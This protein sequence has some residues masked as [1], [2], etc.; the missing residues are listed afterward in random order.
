MEKIKKELR[1]Q[2]FDETSWWN[3]L[4]F[5]LKQTTAEGKPPPKKKPSHPFP[6]DPRTPSLR[7]GKTLNLCVGADFLYEPQ[8]LSPRHV[9]G[10]APKSLN[11]NNKITHQLAKHPPTNAPQ[12]VSTGPSDEVWSES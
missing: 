9:G 10:E 4:K 3:F 7:V 5:Q 6:K 8:G 1:S 2:K 11:Q 12:G